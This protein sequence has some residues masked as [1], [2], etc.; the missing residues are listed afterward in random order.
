MIADKWEKPLQ[1]KIENL[2]GL[3]SLVLL[4]EIEKDLRQTI[5]IFKKCCEGNSEVFRRGILFYGITGTGKTCIAKAIAKEAGAKLITMNA[6]ELIEVNLGK[7]SQR[8]RELF[9]KA[10]EQAPC[11]VFIDE[12]DALGK[13]GQ[14][15]ISGGTQ[16][17]INSTINQLLVELDGFQAS[18]KVLVIAATNRVQLVES[19]LI[20]SGRFDLKIKLEL[21]GQYQR[22][23]IIEKKIK[24]EK[25]DEVDQDFI[26]KLAERTDKFSGADLEALVNEA[27]YSRMHHQRENLTKEDFDYAFDK[28]KPGMIAD[29]L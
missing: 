6:C 12:I 10:R 15:S 9:E 1:K 20:R 13:R 28:L 18:D 27:I 3:D 2:K 22:Y 21:P 29:G 8:V 16:Y 25:H 17:E 26:L 23:L 5:D 11:I 7:G 14:T 24:T 19:A 4:P